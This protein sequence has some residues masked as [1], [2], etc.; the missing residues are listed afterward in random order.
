[1]QPESAIHWDREW[2]DRPV[3]GATGPHPLVLTSQREAVTCQLCRAVIQRAD[4]VA[5]P[6]YSCAGRRTRCS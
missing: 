6:A 4:L 3:C 2:H 5:E 1:M